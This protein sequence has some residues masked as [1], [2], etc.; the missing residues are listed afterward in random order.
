MSKE[1]VVPVVV[2]TNVLIPS[3]Y[4][5]SYLFNFILS[6][7][8]VL[9][10]NQFIYDEAERIAIDMWN[11]YVRRRTRNSLKDTLNLLRLVFEVGYSVHDMPDDWPNVSNDRDD[12]SFLWA[13]ENGK[14][15]YIISHDRRHM[16]ALRSFKGIPIGNPASFFSWAISN[17]PMT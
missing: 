17:Y 6:G 4:R 13:A 8:L 12:D 5:S 15:E 2:D 9:V 11:S 1:I 16:I 10:W 14:A 7:N 3:I